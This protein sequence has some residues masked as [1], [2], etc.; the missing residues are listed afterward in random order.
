MLTEKLNITFTLVWTLVIA[1]VAGAVILLLWGSQAS[2]ITYL[3]GHIIVPRHYAGRL[4]GRLGRQWYARQLDRSACLWI[5][6]LFHEIGGLAS[7]RPLYL[8][9]CSAKSWKKP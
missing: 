3:Q 9:S 5:Y 1:N 6:R 7:D 4:Y 8:D 2:K